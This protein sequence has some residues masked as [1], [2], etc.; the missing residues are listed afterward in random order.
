VYSHA[1]DY[2]I[3][4]SSDPFVHDGP[5]IVFL[6]QAYPENRDAAISGVGNPLKREVYYPEIEN[7][8]QYV[9]SVLRMPVL[10]AIHPRFPYADG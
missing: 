6:D 4:D 3:W 9:S 7:F 10:V 8:L 1:Y 2:V 5:Y